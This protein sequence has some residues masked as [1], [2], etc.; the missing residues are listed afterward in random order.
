MYDDQLELKHHLPYSRPY[1]ERFH[2]SRSTSHFHPCH[3]HIS[4]HTPCFVIA[5]L[6]LK[7][8]SLSIPESMSGTSLPT[9]CSRCGGPLSRGHGPISASAPGNIK[10]QYCLADPT[11]AEFCTLCHDEMTIWDTDRKTCNNCMEAQ[12]VVSFVEPSLCRQCSQECL[13]ELEYCVDCEKNITEVEAQKP[14]VLYHDAL[15]SIDSTSLSRPKRNDSIPEPKRCIDCQQVLEKHEDTAL[16][17]SCIYKAT[18]DRIGFSP[19]K[20]RQDEWKT[21]HPVHFQR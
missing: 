13:P 2:S 3:F 12:L 20:V 14:S 17:F 9:V 11:N 7:Q 5:T 10:C 19:Y 15:R 1:P 6:N 4:I 8:L 18:L 21:S 16:C